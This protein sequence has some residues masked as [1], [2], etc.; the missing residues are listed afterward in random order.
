MIPKQIRLLGTGA[1]ILL[2][3]LLSLNV[4]S[5]VTIGLLRSVSEAR[6]VM[7][8]KKPELSFHPFLY[9]GLL[10]VACSD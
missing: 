10:S 9:L 1:A 5:S 7:K 6:R 3:G 2:G 4:V 8:S